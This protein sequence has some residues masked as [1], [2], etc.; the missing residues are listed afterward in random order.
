[1]EEESGEG[2][3]PSASAPSPPPPTLTRRRRH[4]IVDSPSPA[5]IRVVPLLSQR[6][7]LKSFRLLG[8]AGLTLCRASTGAPPR[9]NP[10]ERPSP[11]SSAPPLSSPFIRAPVSC[12]KWVQTSSC[13]PRAAVVVVDTY[14]SFQVAA[15]QRAF[16]H[17]RRQD[18]RFRMMSSNSG[19]GA[20]GSGG[21][22]GP[23]VGGGGDGRHDDEAALTEFLSSLMD[24]TP[25][26]PDELVEHYLGRS[27]FHCPDL[28]L[29][30]LV[31]VATQKF[32]SDI[33]SDSLQHCKARVA[34]PIKDNKS[35]QPKDRRLVLTMDDLSKALREHGVNLKHPEY[36]ADSP[37]AG[38]APSTREE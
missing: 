35:K 33:A 12:Y 28:R 30:R 11:P 31:A 32:L 24:Y 29:T 3:L 36:F 10:S 21:G 16:S 6:R 27:G 8:A 25:T 5:R 18:V 22:M 15:S 19:G 17:V 34:A 23:G 37:S 26:I 38:M 2:G 20:G 1:M 9:P 4:R 13:R 7:A 14:S